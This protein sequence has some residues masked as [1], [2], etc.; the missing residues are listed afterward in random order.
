MFPLAPGPQ[1]Q[2]NVR[3]FWLGSAWI[4]RTRELPVGAVNMSSST[5]SDPAVALVRRGTTVYS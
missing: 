5:L 2:W 1:L 3:V 4:T